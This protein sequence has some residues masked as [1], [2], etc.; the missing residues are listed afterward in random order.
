M[1]ANPRREFIKS[2][3]AVALYSGMAP[4]RVLGANDRLRPAGIGTGGRARK[5]L[6]PKTMRFAPPN[7]AV[8][9]RIGLLLTMLCCS[10]ESALSQTVKAE[11]SVDLTGP[12]QTI[13]R[14][15]YG[16]FL[17]HF[18]RMIQG[19]LWAE[20]LR[21]RKFYPI[22]PD[23]TQVAQPWR[24]EADLTNISY[25]IDRFVS[26]DGISSQRVSLF[27]DSQTWRGLSQSG[28]DL[29]GG[30]EYT[31]SAW[32][33]AERPGQRVSFRIESANGQFPA[34]AE[35]EI[36]GEGWERYEVRLRPS[37]FCLTLPEPNGSAW[38]LSCHQITSRAMETSAL[39]GRRRYRSG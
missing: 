34:Q 9:V 20:L 2:T 12:R 38:P 3:A 37:G 5:N 33:K 18:G 10:P 25:V 32:I 36:K 7:F 30:K 27:G 13:D 17:E 6:I 15:I 35:A 26:L 31:A 29:R 22:D 8:A 14:R 28:F 39:S 24:P 21:N 4:S 1:K 23:R 19:G 11:F 16:Q